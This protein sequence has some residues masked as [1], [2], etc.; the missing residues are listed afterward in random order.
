MGEINT[1]AVCWQAS[2]Q[3]RRPRATLNPTHPQTPPLPLRAASSQTCGCPLRA[4]RDQCD[5]RERQTSPARSDPRDHVLRGRARASGGSY[6]QPASQ[7]R[8]GVTLV[9]RGNKAGP[10]GMSNYDIESPLQLIFRDLF[11]RLPAFAESH[12]VFLKLEGFNITDSIEVKTAIGLVED[13]EVW[14]GQTKPY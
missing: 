10:S 11:Y 5:D 9:V 3:Q 8:R 7:F 4:K 1:H 12:D 6:A 2:S 13:L 14:L